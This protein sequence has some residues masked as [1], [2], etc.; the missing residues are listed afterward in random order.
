[1]SVGASLLMLGV[2]GAHF[3]NQR[4]ALGLDRLEFAQI[5]INQDA[6]ESN[7]DRFGH[8]LAEFARDGHNGDDER[9]A[10]HLRKFGFRNFARGNVEIRH[11]CGMTFSDDFSIVIRTSFTCVTLFNWEVFDF[12][13]YK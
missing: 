11:T 6:V 10:L 13:F 8:L 2:V 4:L 12:Q 7:L 3:A 5:C 9:R 1:M